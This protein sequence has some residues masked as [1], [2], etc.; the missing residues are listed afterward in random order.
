MAICRLPA[1]SIN[2]ISQNSNIDD[3]II[4]RTKIIASIITCI[5]YVCTMRVVVLIWQM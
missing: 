5:I 3:Y 1:I 4:Y 2:Y